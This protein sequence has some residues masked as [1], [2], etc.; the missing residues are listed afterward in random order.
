MAGSIAYYAILSI[1]P[2]LLG[3]IALL[4]IFLP[5]ETVQAQ[6]FQFFER[7]LPGSNQLI[8][9]NISSIIELRGALGLFSIIGLFWT[10]S[11][12]FGSIGRAINRAWDVSAYRPFY[13][14]KLR[15]L[16]VA[17]G[18]SLLFF[19]SMALTAFSSIIPVIDLPV[20]DSL[21]IIVS[22]LLGFVFIS[23][24]VSLI[25]KF[26]PN[27]KTS[28]HFVWP[29]AILAAVLLEMARSAFTI[30]LN[31]FASYD[32][33]YGSVAT[34]IILLVWIYLSAFILILG[35]EFASEYG[36]MRRTSRRQLP[37]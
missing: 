8:E 3:V 37:V 14:R 33:V 15:D 22:R 21:A 25:Y 4:G 24:M 10:G 28:W 29:G 16:A 9:R 26:M 2:L 6:I 13:V 20:L 32:M 1:F 30:Y 19:L 5:S 7:Y 27:T 35:A 18:T 23:A 34:A 11:A 12:I 31:N 36:R 17:I